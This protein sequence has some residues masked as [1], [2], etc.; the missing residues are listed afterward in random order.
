MN[1]VY[2]KTPVIFFAP[3][4]LSA[5]FKT[6]AN[7][8]VSKSLSFKATVSGRIQDMVKLFASV[9]GCGLSKNQL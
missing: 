1:T 4:T 2:R 7:S 9:E 8:S 6:G 5:S 3:F